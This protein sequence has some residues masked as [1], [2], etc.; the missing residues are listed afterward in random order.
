VQPG[1]EGERFLGEPEFLAKSLEIEADPFAHIHG[2][3]EIRDFYTLGP[4]C[5]WVTFADRHLYWA[6]AE[7]QV[8]WLG[9]DDEALSVRMRKVIDGWHKADISGQP[10]RSDGL[11]TLLNQVAAYRQTICRIKPEGYLTR[12]GSPLRSHERW[13]APG[14]WPAFHVLYPFVSTKFTPLS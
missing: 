14:I 5:L 1:L 2:A 13:T 9:P 8:V 4:D 11:S 7:P 6:F 12:L 3:R 10:L